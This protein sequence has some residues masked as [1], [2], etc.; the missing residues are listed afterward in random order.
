MK[1][2]IFLDKDGT[3]VKFNTYSVDATSEEVLKDVLMEEKILDGLKYFQ[4]KGFKLIVISNQP[5][6]GKGVVTSEQIEDLFK[7]L[8][9]KLNEK[10]IEINDYFYCPHR[11]TDGCD[12]RKPGPK[13]LF[14]AAEKHGI[15]LEES[16]MVGDSHYDIGAGK[17]A[18]IKTVLVKSGE[19]ADFSDDFG[20][21]H[22][23]DDINSLRGII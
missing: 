22:L 14:D 6:I 20:A 21:D 3:L 10:G 1:G 17:N 9:L 12:C 16:Y 23:V 5:W 4:E 15:N 19:H 18:G 2:A 7:E 13:L 11:K 8:V